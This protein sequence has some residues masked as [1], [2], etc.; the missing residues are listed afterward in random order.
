MPVSRGKKRDVSS[1]LAFINVAHP[2]EIRQK[3]TQ[4]AIR[5]GAM[6]AIGR[7]RRKRPL[8]PVTAE[9]DVRLLRNDGTH[10][11][12]NENDGRARTWAILPAMPHLGMFAVEP[13]TRARELL[14]F[15][16]W[17]SGRV[18]FL[19]AI[20]TNYSSKVS[21]EA[22]YVY[23]PFRVEW[24]NMA[25]LDPCSYF[26]CLA[27]AALFMYQH[28]T[29]KKSL[30]YTDSAESA[31]YYSQCL[32]QLTHQLASETER[33]SDGVI[34]TILGFVCHSGSVGHRDRCEMHMKGLEGIIR[35]RG[36]FKGLGHFSSIF[37][38]WFDITNSTS[39]DIPP[40]FPYPAEN[41]EDPT[42]LETLPQ[43]LLFSLKSLDDTSTDLA[44]LQ[45]SLMKM[46]RLASYINQHAHQPHFWEAGMASTKLLGPTAHYLLSISRLD[47]STN[48]QDHPSYS[49]LL[50]SETIRVALF[51]LMAILK[52]GFTLPADELDL[53]LDRFSAITPLVPSLSLSPVF[54]LWAFVLVSCAR[55]D[56][57]SLPQIL[58]MRRAMKDLSIHRV[59]D[60][61]VAAR[62]IIWIP[63][64]LDRNI[65]RVKEQLDEDLIAF[66]YIS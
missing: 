1:G 41:A 34:T 15:S 3:S 52:E 59:D 5:S 22:S 20:A 55:K 4:K 39:Q 48:D 18:I 42:R 21:G 13:D 49:A 66:D 27:N 2:D 37:A 14:H 7:A 47:F 25:I 50:L 19:Y 53:F 65:E 44:P 60:A 62:K 30:E 51:I 64:L 36:G 6:A 43:S 54:R 61:V 29:H 32:S 16:M 33:F 31:K 23:R 35:L 45:E 9:L 17:I 57:I 28:I 12:E 10:E 8:N 38:S 58:E 63:S 56:R 11:I 46:A 24:F 26:L 40:R